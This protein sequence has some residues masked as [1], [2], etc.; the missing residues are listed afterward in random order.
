MRFNNNFTL[1][2]WRSWH[3]DIVKPWLPYSTTGLWMQGCWTVH[4]TNQFLSSKLCI[5]KINKWKRKSYNRAETLYSFVHFNYFWEIRVYFFLWKKKN[6]L[7]V[8][9][10]QNRSH[11]TTP[12]Q[13]LKIVNPTNSRCMMTNS[14][15]IVNPWSLVLYYH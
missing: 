15:P 10:Q 8:S 5:L 9:Q 14:Q 4:R 1:F 7:L 11:K 6:N 12:L 3:L 13:I 2:S